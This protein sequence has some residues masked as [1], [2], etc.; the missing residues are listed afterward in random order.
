MITLF[1]ILRILFG[2]LQNGN[3]LQNLD[4][5]SFERLPAQSH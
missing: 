4:L 3:V 5:D 2:T 1:N